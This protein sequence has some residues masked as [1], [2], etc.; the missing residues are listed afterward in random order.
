MLSP[1]A[2]ALTGTRFTGPRKASAPVLDVPKTST[3]TGSVVAT[4]TVVELTGAV[5]DSLP[6]A[7]V[8]AVVDDAGDVA[9]VHAPSIA[10]APVT[11]TTKRRSLTCLVGSAMLPADDTKE[12]N[13]GL[14][15]GKVA[16]VTGAGRGI[17]RCEALSLASEGAAIVVNDLGAGLDGT[18]DRTNPAQAVVDEITAAGG[19]GIANGDDIAGYSGAEAVVGTAIEH[20]GR[21]DILV[22]NAGILR[23]KMSFN[24]EERDFDD[25]VRVHLKGHFSMSRTAGA[26]WR[27]QHKAGNPIAG[28]IIN[29]TSEA[30]LFGSVGQAN[31]AAAKGGIATLTV[32][33]AREYEHFGVT[34]NAIA[35]RARTRMT[36]S[37]LGA[38]EPEPGAFDTWAPENVAPVVAWLA[39]DQAAEVNGQ[40][41]VVWGGAV[42]LV[43]HY[44][45]AGSIVRDRAWTP[46]ELLDN[47]AELFGDRSS[48]IPPFPFGM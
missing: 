9:E 45:P 20:F 2:N 34:V 39:T 1:G 44:Q 22:N 25:V 19:R 3:G 47:Q 41:F 24:L 15:D 18:G 37:A 32:V 33:L 40:I 36:T 38:L 28:R 29:T 27:G 23:D 10:A 8:P 42:H 4:T 30:G 35:P 26:Y 6:D 43:A 46:Q 17:G 14:L 16:I 31:Y 11:A 13:V 5:V 12:G 7:L 48:G 21:L